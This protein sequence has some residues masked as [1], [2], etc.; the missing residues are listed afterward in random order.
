MN[1]QPIE[2]APKDGTDVDLFVFNDKCGFGVRWTDCFWDG[3][4]WLS[5]DGKWLLDHEH[6]AYWM[7]IPAD[8]EE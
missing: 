5:C 1:W 4:R 8:P 2:T 7:P 3:E 6:A